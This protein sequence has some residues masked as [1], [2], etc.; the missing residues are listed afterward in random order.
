[1]NATETLQVSYTR[2][3]PRALGFKYLGY[4]LSQNKNK[5]NHVQNEKPFNHNNQVRMKIET[6]KM[7]QVNKS[8][9]NGHNFKEQ[10]T[11]SSD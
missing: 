11:S 3:L 10:K 7:H 4:P 2:Q 1:M 6:N 9:K 8:R 5:G